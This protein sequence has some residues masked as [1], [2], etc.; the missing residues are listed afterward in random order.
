MWAPQLLCSVFLSMFDVDRLLG[1][2]GITKLVRCVPR[3]MEN[4]TNWTC[5]ECRHTNVDASVPSSSEYREPCT[6]AEQCTSK[7]AVKL[8]SESAEGVKEGASE[9]AE[10]AEECASDAAECASEGAEGM[11]PYA[12]SACLVSLSSCSSSCCFELLPKS[13]ICQS[14]DELNVKMT[15]VPE[16]CLGPKAL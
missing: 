8:T 6:S 7:G 13:P 4:F 11:C 3:T 16:A 2:H 9:G 10:V 1:R 14:H 5:V 15:Y 12:Y